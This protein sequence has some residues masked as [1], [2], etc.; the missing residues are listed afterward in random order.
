M[1]FAHH[2]RIL[3]SSVFQLTNFLAITQPL[4]HRSFSET[5]LHESGTLKIKYMISLPNDFCQAKFP[6]NIRLLLER[7]L[8]PFL[9]SHKS[10]LDPLVRVRHH[11]NQEVDEDHCG[12]QHIEPKHKLKFSQRLYT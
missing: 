9:M 4:A 6:L 8:T 10:Y 3:N 7:K 2:H 1:F 11:S 12:D 5:F